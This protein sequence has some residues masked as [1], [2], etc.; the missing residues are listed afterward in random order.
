MDLEVLNEWVLLQTM[1][2]L[3]SLREL[4]LAHWRMPGLPESIEALT[5]LQAFEC[6]YS[7]ELVELP[8]ALGAL[9][10]LKLLNLEGCA[11]LR[12]L[13]G[14]VHRLSRLQLLNL[15][16]C[17]NLLHE[18]TS[19]LTQLILSSSPNLVV[20]GPSRST[21]QLLQHLAFQ[22]QLF[23]LELQESVNAQQKELAALSSVEKTKYDRALQSLAN[24]R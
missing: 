20:R 9:T 24:I 1:S 19:R 23:S 17:D 21:D 22:R 3:S 18:G 12:D 11:R 14:S 6:T 7:T 5:G 16:W 10:G 4:I 13:P 15:Q 2:Q 8:E